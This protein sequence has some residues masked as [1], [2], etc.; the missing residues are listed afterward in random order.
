M[1][2]DE[3]LISGNETGDKLGC[4]MKKV[5]T[6]P[7]LIVLDSYNIEGGCGS[8]LENSGGMLPSVS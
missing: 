3:Y 7:T 6:A 4:L 8:I 1:I 5:Y 2:N